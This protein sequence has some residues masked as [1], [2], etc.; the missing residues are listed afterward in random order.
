MI[1]DLIL[2]SPWEW[3]AIHWHSMIAL[4]FIMLQFKN[5]GNILPLDT[6]IQQVKFD[7]WKIR[8]EIFKF[9]LSISRVDCIFQ[10]WRTN[11]HKC[12][13]KQHP[14]KDLV[15]TKNDHSFRSPTPG[16]FTFHDL[17]IAYIGYSSRGRNNQVMASVELYLRPLSTAE[18][19]ST[20]I[21]S[22]SYGSF[23]NCNIFT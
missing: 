4:L 18:I 8:K 15:K 1:L 11:I 3:L 20:M 21:K 6:I 23:Q 14:Y 5:I 22:K 9:L 2:Q 13:V 16:Q 19:N 12:R 17:N 7:W 10:K